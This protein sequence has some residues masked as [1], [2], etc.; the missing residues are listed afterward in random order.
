[1][2]W[3]WSLSLTGVV[4][5]AV[6][7]ASWVL[8]VALAAWGKYRLRAA[9]ASIVLV[10]AAWWVLEIWWR[11]FPDRVDWRVYLAGVGIIF[12]LM[13]LMQRRKVVI[14]SVVL[15]T[16]ATLGTLN[17]VFQE[18]PTVRSFDPK[19]VAVSMSYAQ[20]QHTQRPPR[21]D[22]REVGALVTVDIP[23]S[24][25]RPRPA[26]AYVPPVYWSGEI[27]PVMVLMAGNPGS[28]D[29][30]FH[31]GE[32][33]Q[34]AD[35]YQATHGGAGPIVVSVDATGSFTGNPL[36]VDGPEQQVM[37]YLS[38]DVPE[39]IHRL[40]RVVED[41]A[42]W[43]IGGLSYG[44]TCALQ[45]VTSHPESYGTFLDFSGQAEPTVGDHGQTVA[46][47]FGGSEEAFAA[48]NPADLLATRSYPNTRG[49]FVAGERD[50]DSVAAL[51]HLNELAR[52][53]GMETSMDT[54]PGG[55]SFEVWRVALAETFEWAVQ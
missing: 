1:M 24:G 20:F 16:F 38:R 35:E 54:V 46:R 8:G 33:A 41:R 36:C 48:H 51:T 5:Q 18:Y 3:L 30:W 4:A 43:V 23:G 6:I 13:C 7:L 12:S 10:V 55:H 25:F 47:F 49:R 22:G 32:A 2:N 15:T 21:L 9:G 27:L 31:N 39:G 11:P 28:P 19:P 17:L 26:V 37:T 34:T 40:F 52:A 53:A 50:K 42:R 29:Q 45:V 44:G 14:I